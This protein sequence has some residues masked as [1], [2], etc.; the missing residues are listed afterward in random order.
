MSPLIHAT[1]LVR[2]ASTFNELQSINSQPLERK[3]KKRKNY[4]S[5]K[6]LLTS[7][8]EKGL[9]GKKSPFTRISQPL[10]YLPCYTVQSV[11]HALPTFNLSLGDLKML[12]FSKK[13][14]F[15]N[16]PFNG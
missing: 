3:E 14:S 10:H 5:S 12:T 15:F 16:G 9:L 11:R 2:F 13:S 8:K 4:A 7:I 1:K 6:T